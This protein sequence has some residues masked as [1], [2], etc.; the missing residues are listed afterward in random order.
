MLLEKFVRLSL[1]AILLLSTS[2]V[3]AA[4]ENIMPLGDSITY[5][6]SGTETGGYRAPLY[7]DLTSASFNGGNFQFVGS[8]TGDPGSLP[9]N[10]Q[11]HEGHPGYR[12]DQIL[13]GITP[14]GS[15]G[16]GWLNVNPDLVLLHIGTN[17]AGQGIAESTAVA[18]VASI[19]D[20][21]ESHNG[22]TKV[23]LAE[24]L[25]FPGH[26]SWISQFNSDLSALAATKN[27]AGDHVTI[28]DMNTNY[29]SSGNVL[30]DGVHPNAAGYSWMAQQWSTA[31]TSSSVAPAT[32]TWNASAGATVTD[33]GGSWDTS[34]P[35]WNNG[36]GNVA[37]VNANNDIATIGNHNGPAGTI[38]LA[39]GITV[40][41]LVFNPASS[42]NYT[43]AGNTLTF[44]GAGATVT[45][46]VDATISSAIAGSATLVKLG[47]NM[48][49]LNG[50]S[51]YT[52]SVSV[53]GGTLRVAPGGSLSLGGGLT[54]NG[55][56]S[57]ANLAGDFN[58][59]TGS[60][61]VT[62]QNGGVL[63]WSGTGTIGGASTGAILVGSGSAGTFNMT[64]GTLN[65]NYA[66]NDGL[67]IGWQ[68]GG[69]GSLNISGGTINMSSGS[70]FLVG[71]GGS[72]AVG[73][74]T[75]GGTGVLNLAAGAQVFIGGGVNGSNAYGAGTWTINNGGTVNVAAGGGFPNDNV[76][77]AGYGGS[78]VINL[79]GGLLSSARSFFNGGPSTIN[80][81][82]GTL[83]STVSNGNLISVNN[84]YVQAGGAVFDTMAN[85]VV[86]NQALQHDPALGATL[87]GGLTKIGSGALTLGGAN[88][89]TGATTINGGILGAGDSN[90]G[91]GATMVVLN[92][93]TLQNS[94]AIVAAGRP[95]VLGAAGGTINTNGSTTNFSLVSGNGALTKSGAGTLNLLGSSS[96]NGGAT[97]SQGTL[98]VANT[99][100]L[101]AGPVTLSG[102][103]LQLAGRLQ[104]QQHA[105][106]VTGFNQDVIWGNGESA[107]PA[108]G[109][110]T[111]VV[112]W[113]WYEHGAGA[114]SQGLPVNSGAAPRTFTSAYNGA[115][116]FQ[117]APYA[118]A[119][120]LILPTTG[121]NGALTL[122]TP[123]SFQAIQFLTSSQLS[124]NWTATLNFAD[125]APTTV[126]SGSDIDWTFNGPNAISNI[127][128][129]QQNNTGYYAN[130]LN[131]FEHDF[132]LSPADQARTL[133]SITFNA[134]N[135]AGAGLAV[136]AVSGQDAA[137]AASQTYANTINVTA[138]SAIDIQST[139][140][141][142]V[143]PLSIGAATLSVTGGSGANLSFG[144][145]TLTGNAT[146][147]PASGVT[148][149]LSDVGD[150]GGNFSLTQNGAGTTRITGSAT[151]GGAT[152]VSAGALTVASTGTLNGA[153]G[154][155]VNGSSAVANLGGAFNQTTGGGGVSI[156]GGGTVN[157]SGAGTIGQ[158]SAGTILI[159]NGSVGTFNMTGG[160]L[161]V[162]Y[163]N[164][165]GF[166]I[167]WNDNGV[168]TLNVSGGAITVSAGDVFYLGA[169]AATAVGT[170]NVT[171]AGVLNIG[172]GGGRI[173][174][175]GATAGGQPAG[176]G[177]LNVASGGVINV[178][179]AGAFPN[180]RVYLAGFGGSGTINVNA[181]GLLSTA[182]PFG[183]GGTSVFNFNGGTLQATTSLND[184]INVNNGVIIK[185][186]GGTIDTMANTVTQNAPLLTDP[187]LGAT[188]DGGLTKSGGGSLTL[189]AASTY[190]GGTSINGGTLIVAADPALGAAAGALRFNGGALQ[191]AAALSSARPVTFNAAGGTVN[192][193]GF[194]ST[195]SG[196]V[197]GGGQLI[198]TGAGTL[199]L[200][201]A[202]SGTG[203]ALVNQGV[204]RVGAAN[205]LGSGT[206]TLAGGTLQ[207][208]G[209]SQAPQTVMPISSGFNQDIIWTS[210]EGTHPADGTTTDFASWV[211]YEKGTGSGQFGLP[212]N[213]GATPRTFTSAFNPSV[214]FQF[215]PYGDSTARNNNG[216]IL[217]SGNASGTL[218]LATPGHFQSLQIL[219][220]SQQS[221]V[222]NA[223]LY[224]T[225]NSHTT[226]ANV[227]DPDWVSNGQNALLNTGLVQ[228]N[229]SGYYGG[230]LNL[231]EHDFVLSGTD[232]AKTLDH[233]TINGVNFGGLGLVV[234]GL[235]GQTAV[236][237]P[238][239]YSN[240]VSLTSDS[241]IDLQTYP[242]ATLGNL[243]IGSNKLSITGLGGGALTLGAT[244]L[245]GNPTFDVAA[246]TA[247]ALGALD[248]GGTPR[249]I[250]KSSAGSLTLASPAA[251]LV[252]GTQVNITAGTLNSNH[253]TA[254]GTLAAVDVSGGA[255]LNLGASQQIGALTNVGTVRL[256]GSTLTVGSTNNL[257]S[258]F[259][260]VIAD[261]SSA[262][263]L[264]KSGGGTFSLSGA[265]S[266]SGGTTVAQGTLAV[267]QIVGSTP[268]GSGSVTLAG[269]T[270]RLAGQNALV[271]V[272]RMV[273][274]SGYNQDLIW[275][276]GEAATPAAATTNNLVSWDWY[277]N[278]AGGA[279]VPQGL[280]VNSGAAPR[281][282]TSA[283][284]SSVQF[285]LADYGSTAG[286]NNNVTIVT[287]GASATMMLAT[288][289]KFQ[290]LQFL[291]TSQG[292]NNGVGTAW[293][294][295]LNFADG[296]QSTVSVANE[297]DWTRNG[298]IALPNTGLV[299][300]NNSGYYNNQLSLFEHDFTLSAADQAKTLSS[301]TLNTTASSGTG[302][303]FFA[304][305][306]QALVAGSYSASQSYANAINV[307]ADS[308]I[309]VQNS[310]AASVGALMIGRKQLSL[311]GVSGASAT[312][313]PVTLTGNATFN[314][315]PNTSFA[316]GSIGGAAGNGI[317]VTGGGAVVLGN[318]NSFT[319]PINIAG[320]T[321]RLAD[322]STNNVA[323]SPSINLSVGGTLDV[324]GL[325][326]GA[327]R[328]GAGATTQTLAGNGAIHG[329][330][331]VTSGS[332][333]GGVSGGTLAIDGA[334]GL[335]LNA[336][337][338]S[339][340]A[341]AGAAP[342]AGGTGLISLTTGSL[343][344]NGSGSPFTIAITGAS[345]AA[346][347]YDLF[348]FPTG[349]GPGNGFTLSNLTGQNF[350]LNLTYGAHEIDLVVTNPSGTSQ[351]NSTSSG[352]WSITA[353]W[354]GN[355]Y[356]NGLD[357]TGHGQAATLGNGA[358]VNI[359]NPPTATIDVT[360]DGSYSIGS[361]AVTNNQGT[362]YHVLTGGAGTGLTLNNGGFGA[363]VS[364]AASAGNPT[365][366]ANLAL[367]DTAGATF[368]VASGST[369]DVSGVVSGTGGGL[370]K[371]GA[372]TLRLDN[373]NTYGGN[374]TVNGGTL[375]AM[376]SS[377]L[378]AGG[379]TL[380][381]NGSGGIGTLVDLNAN[382]SLSGLSGSIA[383]GSAR[384][385]VRSG[386]TLTVTGGSTSSAD[387]ELGAVGPLPI[388]TGNLI[389]NGAGV[390]E[391]TGAT[392]FHDNSAIAVSGTGGLKLISASGSSIGSGVTATV[393]SGST[394]ELAGSQSSLGVSGGNRATI[395]N[396]GGLIV[397]GPTSQVV[398]GIDN[399]D[400]TRGTIALNSGSNLTVDH[401]NQSSLS[402][403]SGAT[404]TLN[405]SDPSGNP[406]SDAAA[407][408]GGGSSMSFASLSSTGAPTGGLGSLRLAQL[409]ATRPF[410]A[411]VGSPSLLNAGSSSGATAS[412][413][414]SLGGGLSGSGVA[415]VP[416]P[417]T[418]GAVV[419]R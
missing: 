155:S 184:L 410:G 336:G 349:T 115:V 312:T 271:T 185:A 224:F 118:G 244:T 177:F 43:I 145:T 67:G 408:L 159:G 151:Y 223:T 411:G 57:V 48:L 365:I 137:P 364:V 193:G 45:T 122:T 403:G 123:G 346:G 393:G 144:T 72:T 31:V 132:A 352:N 251:S 278:G 89:Y 182:R 368:S 173:F 34:T 140:S 230:A 375:R 228:Y 180:D 106:G 409:L 303:A 329:A 272:Q 245:S 214:Q 314:P 129:V 222:W 402:I 418:L 172:G 141:A 237:T 103:T 13:Q 205:S 158:A 25:P 130:T 116:Q 22:L 78:G 330:V 33:G 117:Y 319:G 289:G 337:S 74:L 358:T 2:T 293:N 220:T 69:V 243:T 379:G 186:G 259:A 97:I 65:V 66:N 234:F 187:S 143:G 83:Q 100:A 341:L 17:D 315:A 299:Q 174:I 326:S 16:L 88:T 283:F 156:S 79:N 270:L 246:G 131:M 239:M 263:A 104:S 60:G 18:N 324:S 168:G 294:A 82:G 51:N 248:D 370:V 46:N 194:N 376:G 8:V 357:Q 339:S 382:Q 340:F 229:N 389:K 344:L 197:N 332:T 232:Q 221:T 321:L 350:G 163:A 84:A 371:T 32:L 201:G 23:Y 58:L 261:G 296:S 27:G 96:G 405:A 313:G 24:I 36:S 399:S 233:V 374:S 120:S 310:G 209:Q 383:G 178:S 125:G 348:S 136:F 154:L 334:G 19:I 9:A 175:G 86:I 300:N 208:A 64:G 394:L 189:N 335:T 215:A 218:S 267:S 49:T 107:A 217:K 295:T 377:A 397:T 333:I 91:S 7:T 247:L 276:N 195:L 80:F 169:G 75:I 362:T 142:T 254:L 112:S 262:G 188:L 316:L 165:N 266:H 255:S 63:N 401:V 94:S 311:T 176:S 54:V 204:L 381:V 256:N 323:A 3:V 109:T 153:G 102:G 412:S 219:T 258:S 360:V 257:S 308:T 404:F 280:P 124:T 44:G 99:A 292:D 121:A 419:A 317:N 392:K 113:D 42:G 252:S 206:V 192:T 269:G 119:N 68:Q 345:V 366:S 76:Y 55:A 216:M 250:T 351:W 231:F 386:A 61:N 287:T 81:N 35:N 380:T 331:V 199:A 212:V 191:T 253:A 40:G 373:H 70:T 87:D 395:T 138:N 162:N 343:T 53:S 50:A 359:A 139:S 105:V 38:A 225:D 286:R 181:G 387:L 98:R 236:A 384:V 342:G 406:L 241:T 354:Q 47:A 361:L 133:T 135:A 213:S 171:A 353:L 391:V 90:L 235:S 6:N 304:L 265:N 147:A 298:Q 196:A 325:Q 28:V 322:G 281:T 126:V 284:N 415:A 12:T 318:S 59:T 282:F 400:S 10:Q 167:G 413:G 207:L 200:I 273:P 385:Q 92:G 309:D 288:P 110:T 211:W 327:I 279:G 52:G 390:L 77:L 166:G 396:D 338:I 41:G 277:E 356:P 202:N 305:S 101:G 249:T 164:T 227:S 71:F 37:W 320:G 328:L 170:V 414:A 417:S 407:T 179:P 203:G 111:N 15:G 150:G 56:G 85:G 20:A 297:A 302:L 275:G 363:T 306:G 242:V 146:V 355:V 11:A 240:T 73:T 160:S 388:S 378:G 301:V 134:T 14:V 93:G 148:L 416:E 190:T 268:L 198:K 62:T 157:W 114:G 29:F 1:F 291:D 226:T 183:A 367:G 39:T 95:L 307:T 108:G 372:G 398:G 210:G 152:N 260:G 285:Q 238:Q 30:P 128:L 274:V 369:L 5:G 347:T 127:G 4:T 149:A 161:N 264:V 26:D 21:I 290:S